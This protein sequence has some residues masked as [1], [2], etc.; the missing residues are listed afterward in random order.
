MAD[1]FC[2][3]Q[4]IRFRSWLSVT[5]ALVVKATASVFKAAA[6]L[7]KVVLLALLI[8]VALADDPTRP[9]SWAAAAPA[10]KAQVAAPVNLAL[11][12]IINGSRRLAVINDKVVTEG[13]VISGWRVTA[14]QADSV[15]LQ[16]GSQQRTLVWAQ[17][18]IKSAAT[19]RKNIR[20]ITTAEPDPA[21]PQEHTGN[22]Q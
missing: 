16:R 17:A 15:R 20:I 22:G 19:V 3:S 1:R 11:R 9:P 4:G 12:Q 8:P 10:K 6:P 7:A 13:G 18:S 21:L 2:S 14:I 5:A